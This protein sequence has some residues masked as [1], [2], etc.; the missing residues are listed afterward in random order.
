MPLVLTKKAQPFEVI[1]IGYFRPMDV[2]KDVI[3]IE[4]NSDRNDIKKTRV[5]EKMVHLCLFT[6]AVSIAVHLELVADL[7]TKTFMYA[8][9]R[10]IT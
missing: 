9:K 4:K 7:T 3:V 6:C 5:G 10:M 2:L 1:G 8:L